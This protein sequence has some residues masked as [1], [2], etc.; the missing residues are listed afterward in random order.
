M[1]TMSRQRDGAGTATAA[2]RVGRAYFSGLDS[3]GDGLRICSSVPTVTTPTVE[4][5]IAKKV[6]GFQNHG[7]EIWPRTQSSSGTGAPE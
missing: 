7:F 4:S 2:S 3:E 1:N 5:R 6:S